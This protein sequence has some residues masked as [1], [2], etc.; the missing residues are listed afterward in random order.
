MLSFVIAAFFIITS[1]PQLFSAEGQKLDRV[2]QQPD[3]A[4]G[5]R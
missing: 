5:G 1:A 3:C 4:V 2:L